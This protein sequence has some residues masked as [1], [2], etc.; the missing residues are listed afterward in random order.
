MEA[1]TFE[2]IIANI[3]RNKYYKIY[4]K[5]VIDL[6]KDQQ[7]VLFNK[8]LPHVKER[9]NNTLEIYKTRP[10]KV[11]IHYLNGFIRSL[12]ENLRPTLTEGHIYAGIIQFLDILHK[13]PEGSRYNNN[14]PLSVYSQMGYLDSS[15]DIRLPLSRVELENQKAEA[16]LV[17]LDAAN[18]ALPPETEWEVKLSSTKGRYY[19]YNPKTGESRWDLPSA[20]PS[21]PASLETVTANEGE[22]NDEKPPPPPPSTALVAAGPVQNHPINNT[23][24]RRALRVSRTGPPRRGVIEERNGR[25]V[26]NNRNLPRGS[27]ALALALDSPGG[28]P[29]NTRRG[30]GAG[31]PMPN[32]R[33]T[34]FN[35]LPIHV[36]PALPEAN[37][38]AAAV[39]SAAAARAAAALAAAPVHVP[40]GFSAANNAA[41]RAGRLAGNQAHNIT[42]AVQANAAPGG[43]AVAASSAAEAAARAARALAPA[44]NNQNLPGYNRIGG[45]KS[46]KSRKSRKI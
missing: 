19:Y 6:P 30:N 17:A 26:S 16:A 11:K 35:T 23:R 5:C 3:S 31:I 28:Q 21:A 14:T 46:R 43:A 15:K 24:A 37:A 36:Y 45:G 9:L 18:A 40:A 29:R 1:C 39:R 38:R 25:R 2:N 22:T 32:Q 8:L 10:K 4:K 41:F 13:I 27:I 20:A 34:P 44:A 33:R 12:D 42:Q 7:K